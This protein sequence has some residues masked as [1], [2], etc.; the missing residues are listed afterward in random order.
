M[1]LTCIYLLKKYGISYIA[2]R[3]SKANNK[4]MKNYDNT[5][6]SVYVM[7]FDANNLYGWSMTQYLP[8]D[9]FK[10]MTEEEINDFDFSLAEKNS[11][12]GYILEVD[13]E[14]PSELH[15]L[16]NDHPLAP[17]KFKVNSDML[18]GYCSEIANKYGIKVGEVNKLIPNLG[19]K[20]NY[21]IHYRNLQLY[22]SLGMRVTKI[23]KVLKFEQSDWLK[24]FV[25]FNTEKRKNANNKF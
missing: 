2:K 14:Y 1:I 3:N 9:G 24:M 4:Y 13:L 12:N 18:S 20:K 8:Y 16:H 7:Y 11:L 15:D 17:E 5:K 19:N 22:V 25:D 10:W 23:H 21:V 6:K